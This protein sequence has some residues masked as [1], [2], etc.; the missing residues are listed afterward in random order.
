MS[1]YKGNFL[2]ERERVDKK[3]HRKALLDR[4]LLIAGTF[5]GYR[6]CPL[7]RGSTVLYLL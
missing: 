2:R 5:S 1:P 7:E 4:H 3:S 6:W